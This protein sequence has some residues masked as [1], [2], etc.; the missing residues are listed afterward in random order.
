LIRIRIAVL[1]CALL[2]AGCA[3]SPPGK[4]GVGGGA[5]PS[6]PRAPAQA[7]PRPA[8]F[9]ASKIPDVLLRALQDAYRKPAPLDCATLGAEIL[10]LDAVLGPDLDVL[11]P[12]DRPDDALSGAVTGAVT[13]LIPY[14]GLLRFLSGARQRERRVALAIAAGDTRRGYLKGRGEALRCAVPAAPATTET[15]R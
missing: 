6:Q 7:P 12:A 1:A 13:G 3:S 11:K 15:V 14:H 5:A 8:K 10:A 9:S 4:A 2:I